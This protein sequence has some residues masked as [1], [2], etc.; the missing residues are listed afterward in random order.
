MAVLL[1]E[2]TLDPIELDDVGWFE[3]SEVEREVCDPCLEGI[4]RP[5]SPASK[6]PAPR[7]RAVG[8]ARPTRLD[9]SR[10]GD[11]CWDRLA[12]PTGSARG[13][14]GMRGPAG[15]ARKPALSRATTPASA[16]PAESERTGF[17]RPVAQPAACG[18]SHRRSSEG[19]GSGLGQGVER[20]GVPRRGHAGPTKPEEGAPHAQH[21]KPRL[22]PID[23]F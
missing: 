20:V 22:K 21:T 7:R 19:Q 10:P 1:R 17:S 2:D 13:A 16:S 23:V 8:N 11:T 9:S 4:E 15:S 6:P 12:R 14:P 18:N 5:L 3:A